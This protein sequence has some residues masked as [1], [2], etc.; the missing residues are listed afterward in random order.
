MDRRYARNF[1]LLTHDIQNTI[2]WQTARWLNQH[3]TGERVLVPGSSAFWLTAFS[4]TPELWGF[5][6]GVTDYIIRAA[7]YALYA[8]AGPQDAEAAVL[9]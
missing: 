1:L 5:D 6:Q 8:G 2:E 3:W 7:E 4:D 9:W